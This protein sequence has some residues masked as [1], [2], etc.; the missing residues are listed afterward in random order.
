MFQHFPILDVALF[1]FRMV[2]GSVAMTGTVGFVELFGFVEFVTLTGDGNQGNRHE[3][4]GEKFHR[5][6]S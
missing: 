6:A 5:A 1:G 4:K 3:Q 2:C